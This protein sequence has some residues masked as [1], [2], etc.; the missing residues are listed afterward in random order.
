MKPIPLQRTARGMSLIEVLVAL[1]LFSFGVLGFVALQAKAT[2]ISMDAEDRTRAAMLADELI[3]IMWTAGTASLPESTVTAWKDKV[4][5]GTG[6]GLRVPDDAEPTV[7]TDSSGI[8]TITIRWK[9]PYKGS[10]TPLSQYV[11]TVSIQ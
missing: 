4:R 7:S 5:S 6:S 3:S 11:T 9:P 1:L 8:T 2:G 10:S